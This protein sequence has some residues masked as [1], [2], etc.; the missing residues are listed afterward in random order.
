MREIWKEECMEGGRK[1]GRMDGRGMKGD[2]DIEGRE[3]R[4]GGRVEYSLYI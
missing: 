2:M 3:G 1:I 4:R